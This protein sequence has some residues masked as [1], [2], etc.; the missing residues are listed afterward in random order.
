MPKGTGTDVLKAYNKAVG[1]LEGK[2]G[3]QMSSCAVSAGTIFAPGQKRA[4]RRG[5]QVFV[6]VIRYSD[7]MLKFDAK[8]GGLHADL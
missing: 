4:E 7:A 1:R 2:F 6:K 3:H 5:Y 8:S